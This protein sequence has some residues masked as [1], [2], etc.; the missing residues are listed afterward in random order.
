MF[1]T[2]YN[3]SYICE[4]CGKEVFIKY[5]SGRFCS[6]ACANSRIRTEETKRKIGQSCKGKFIAWKESHP[7]E[8]KNAYEKSR[9]SRKKNI[10]KKNKETLEKCKNIKTVKTKT[11]TVKTRT[12]RIGNCTYC[13]KEIDITDRKVN[14]TGR[15]YCNGTCRNL[16]LNA[17]KEI[18]GLHKGYNTSKWEREFQDLLK[19]YNIAFEANKR[20]LIPSHYEIDI[21]LPIQKIA[22]ELNGIWHYS[23]KPYNGNIDA[24]KRRQDKDAIKKSQVLALGYKYFVFEDRNITNTKEF[25]ENFIKTEILRS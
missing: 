6:R 11:E 22:I 10:Q 19:Q 15:Y 12:I 1:H 9:V 25:F 2:N 8:W 5:G 17:T 3:M 4:H 16:H 20:D 21:W 18:G 7:E 23:V 13:G 14:K 24:L